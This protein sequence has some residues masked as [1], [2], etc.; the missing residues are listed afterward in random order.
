MSEASK[1]TFIYI[2]FF[3]FIFLK[4]YL[5]FLSDDGCS[6]DLERSAIHET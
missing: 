4:S 2:N 6:V 1:E 3:F 5:D